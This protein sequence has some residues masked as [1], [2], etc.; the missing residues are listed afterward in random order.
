MRARAG[1]A[2]VALGLVL[3]V[4][5]VVPP[6][7]AADRAGDS[8]S[9]ASVGLR[10]RMVSVGTRRGQVLVPPDARRVG[11][12]RGSMPPTAHAGSTLVVGHIA[13][14][15][16]RPGALTVLAGV[17]RGARIRTRWHGRVQWWRVSRIS[18]T[19]RTRD[20]PA[21]VWRTSGSHILN[22]VTCAHRVIYPDG[23]YH[24][25]DNLTVTAVPVGSRL[26]VRPSARGSRASTTRAD[27]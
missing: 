27:R 23:Y 10:A 11:W 13:D 3:G 19:P 17:R 20:L 18:Y 26:A 4:A 25:R 21:R 5:G 7:R 6:A 9:I 2:T 24:Y 1:W 14:P 12:W 16:G 22:L 8:V 15:H